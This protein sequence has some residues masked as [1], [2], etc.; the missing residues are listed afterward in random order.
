MDQQLR[1]LQRKYWATGVADDATSQYIA[2]LERVVGLHCDSFVR[3]VCQ[4]CTG[5]IDG[6]HGSWTTAGAIAGTWKEC[7]V[8]GGTGT[9][10][11]PVHNG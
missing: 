4:A 11:I 7:Q 8:C 2:A 1:T 9:V 10:T 6:K 3:E 5:V